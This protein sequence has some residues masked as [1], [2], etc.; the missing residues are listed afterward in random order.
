LKRKEA[1]FFQRDNMT[2]ARIVTVTKRV[3]PGLRLRATFFGFGAFMFVLTIVL[4]VF[5]G[6]GLDVG[7]VA[8][9]QK[10]RCLLPAQKYA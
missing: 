2:A 10:T 3:P 7:D 8:T 6:T 9:L 1:I 5:S 4:L